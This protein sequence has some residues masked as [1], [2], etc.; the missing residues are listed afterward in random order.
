MAA[1]ST[2]ARGSG[3][4]GAGTRASPGTR[5]PEAGDAEYSVA[6][7]VT[8][9]YSNP[10]YNLP[11]NGVVAKGNRKKRDKPRDGEYQDL[12]PDSDPHDY[13]DLGTGAND[14]ERLDAKNRNQKGPKVM[15]LIDDY[16]KLGGKPT[17]PKTPEGD[18]YNRLGTSPRP[19]TT[20]AGDYNRLGNRPNK[21]TTP[22]GNEY[23]RLG[24]TKLAKPR[25]PKGE[26]GT[27]NKLGGTP[28]TAKKSDAKPDD[29]DRLSKSPKSPRRKPDNYQELGVEMDSYDHLE[30]KPTSPKAT[31]VPL[32]DY[33]QLNPDDVSGVP[34]DVTPDY[35]TAEDV[36]TAG[37]DAGYEIAVPA[38]VAPPGGGAENEAYSDVALEPRDEDGDYET[39]IPDR[40]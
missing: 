26:G 21:P 40:E 17:K 23:N 22:E 33:S 35:A 20:E 30:T 39:C 12:G 10:T 38:V 3:T 8:D 37:G 18:E 15:T 4:R 7:P 19:K 16:N 31:V 6:A 27:H 1:S 14:Y 5:A 24:G 25:T 13:Q 9:G 32:H 34:D 2:G 28:L 29:Y 11:A 36:V